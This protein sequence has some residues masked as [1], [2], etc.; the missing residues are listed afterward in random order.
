[1]RPYA[2]GAASE[3]APYTGRAIGSLYAPFAVTVPGCALAENSPLLSQYLSATILSLRRF[4]SRTGSTLCSISIDTQ[5]M[6]SFN[7]G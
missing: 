6:A 1:M 3:D 4:L 2:V 7:K 5:R